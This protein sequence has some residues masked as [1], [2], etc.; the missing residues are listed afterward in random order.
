MSGADSR[1][2]MQLSQDMGG[3]GPLDDDASARTVRGSSAFGLAHFK[4]SRGIYLID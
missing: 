2:R 3:L 4:P 1:V